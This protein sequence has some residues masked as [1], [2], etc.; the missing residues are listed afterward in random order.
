MNSQ[1]ARRQW[2]D[3]CRELTHEAEKLG[4]PAE[5]ARLIAA[6]LGSPRAIRRMS[7][8]LRQARPRRIEDVAD[9]M[10]AIQTDVENWRKKKESE[11]A[12][13]AYTSWLRSEKRADAGR[14]D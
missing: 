8:Y 12:N 5:F 13:A 1:D 2:Q 10:L 3:A 9:E 11:Q 4:F 14:E 7:S 6:Q